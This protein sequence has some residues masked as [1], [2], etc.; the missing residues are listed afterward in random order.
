MTPLTSAMLQALEARSGDLTELELAIIC[1]LKGTVPTAPRFT[2]GVMRAYN[3]I[4]A[5][6]V[7]ARNAVW[8][9]KVGA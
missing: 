1:T 8:N 6:T 7:E 2:G 9:Q 4:N 5:L 3:R